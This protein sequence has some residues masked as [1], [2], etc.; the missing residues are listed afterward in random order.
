MRTVSDTDRPRLA[1]H[2]RMA[3][4]PARERHVL[5]APEAV[6]VLGGSGSAVLGLCDGERTVAEIVAELHRRYDHVSDDEVRLFLARLAAK[7][8]VEVSDG[9][10]E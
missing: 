1:P 3:F 5:L 10:D 4:D 9:S 7:R 8:Y 6:A 2:A